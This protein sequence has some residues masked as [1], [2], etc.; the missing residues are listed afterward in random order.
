M[1][2]YISFCAENGGRV[3]PKQEEPIGP[4]HEAP[5]VVEARMLHM[6]FVEEA[7]WKRVQ[8]SRIAQECRIVALRKAQER[9]TRKREESQRLQQIEE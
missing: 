1:D 3:I 4:P 7:Y 2:E 8:A 9:A 6:D 5:I